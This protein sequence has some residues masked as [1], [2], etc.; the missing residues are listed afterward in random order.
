MKTLNRLRVA[1]L[2]V[3]PV[4]SAVDVNAQQLNNAGSTPQY[5]KGKLHT[6]TTAPTFQNFTQDRYPSYA[7][8]PSPQNPVSVANSLYLTGRTTIQAADAYTQMQYNKHYKGSY[9]PQW[10]P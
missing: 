9:F 8:P 7:L 1:A 2:A 4:F 5:L 10:K 3:L 6:Y